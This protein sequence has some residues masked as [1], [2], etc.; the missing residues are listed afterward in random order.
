[1]DRLKK[2]ELIKRSLG[3][4][5]KLKVHDS[6]KQPETHEE[7]AISLIAKW[8]LEDEL[9]AIEELLA[10]ERLGNVKK[11]REHYQIQ[12]TQPLPTVSSEPLSESLIANHDFNEESEEEDSIGNR[13]NHNQNADS[14]KN[15][16]KKIR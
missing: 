4:R 16:K 14:S 7:M 10:E 15:N 6:M 12:E 13:A 1:M 3:L 11:K 8:E 5:H 9:R 2:L